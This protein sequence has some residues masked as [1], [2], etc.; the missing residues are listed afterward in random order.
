MLREVRGEAGDEETVLV[1]AVVVGP[2][3]VEPAA[4]AARR[5]GVE[6]RIEAALDE[7]HARRNPVLRGAEEPAENVPGPCRRD[8]DEAVRDRLLRAQD[9]DERVRHGFGRGVGRHA[10]AGAKRLRLEH[11]LAG[12]LPQQA[13]Q[14]QRRAGVAELKPAQAIHRLRTPER[15]VG[16]DGGKRPL[17]AP[18]LLRP[19]DRDLGDGVQGIAEGDIR[20]RAIRDEHHGLG[21]AAGVRRLARPC[22]AV[23]RP[24]RGC[25]ERPLRSLA[26]RLRRAASKPR[27][28]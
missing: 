13:Q 27:A 11:R 15:E 12:D 3:G 2:Y 8:L 23:A 4:E 21:G 5:H 25:A 7:R 9:L 28:A 19:D 26:A 24:S 10:G 16:D 14:R 18:I 6:D 22:I 1:G 20:V 17:P